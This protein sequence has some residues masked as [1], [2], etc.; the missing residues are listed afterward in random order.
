MFGRE[1]IIINNGMGG[2]E[3]IETRNGLFGS[4]TEVIN[5]GPGMGMGM[6]GMG[7]GMGGSEV[8]VERNGLFGRQE[9]IF[10]N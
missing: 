2:Q 6:G 4:T 1:E 10:V 8:I 5:T 9:E 3:I 7:M